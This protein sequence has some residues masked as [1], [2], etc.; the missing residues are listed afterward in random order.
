MKKGLLEGDGG[1]GERV[2]EVCVRGMGGKIGE[3]FELVFVGGYKEFGV[4]LRME[5]VEGWYII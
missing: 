2:G 3:V 4:G 1:E 5:G